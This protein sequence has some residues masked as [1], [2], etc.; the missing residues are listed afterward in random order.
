MIPVVS[1][2]LHFEFFFPLHEVWGRPGE[3]DPVLIG[4]LIGGEQ[5][6]VEYVMDS[7]GG[8]ELELIGDRGD[9]F[10]DREGAMTSRGQFVRLIGQG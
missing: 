8:W 3:V 4:L 10:R 9:P 1:D 7:P 2:G 6:G 5:R